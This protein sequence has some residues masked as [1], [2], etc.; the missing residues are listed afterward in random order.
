MNIIALCGSAHVGK[1]TAARMLCDKGKG[2]TVAF[3]DRLKEICIEL[4]EL[5]H[6]HFYDEQGKEEPTKFECPTCPSCGSLE[7]EVGGDRAYCRACRLS[8]G[9]EEFIAH[10]TGRTIAQFIGFNCFRRVWPRVWAN[11]TFREARYYLGIGPH[12]VTGSK[13]SRGRAA[14]FVVISDCHFLDVECEMVWEVGGE[15]WRI[16]RPEVEGLAPGIS[17]HASETGP[18][19]VPDSKCQAVIYNDSTLEV[20]RERLA[21]EF[22]RF[23]SERGLH[24]PA[25]NPH[26][27]WSSAIALA[28]TLRQSNEHGVVWT[29]IRP[30]ECSCERQGVAGSAVVF[31]GG[32]SGEHKLCLAVSDEAR[33][34]TH[35]TGYAATN[36]E[37]AGF[38]GASGLLGSTD[39][40]RDR[41]SW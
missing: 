37:P 29:E 27:T 8:A 9:L 1:D 3:A 36:L 5:E 31:C 35:F 13:L 39:P 6:R 16:R 7:V 33:I 14:Q 15:V 38:C 25:G 24:K 11:R 40:I 12:P 20:F 26:W 41:S 2:V 22:A 21:A 23:R 30:Y 28:R 10:W 4:F 19:A 18:E 32:R 17:G 34:R